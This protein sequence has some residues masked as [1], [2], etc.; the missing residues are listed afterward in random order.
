MNSWKSQF[1]RLYFCNIFGE[2]THILLQENLTILQQ[3]ALLLDDICIPFNQP[4]FQ[5]IILH[6][7]IIN[8]GILN[9]Y[10]HYTERHL[11]GKI[12]PKTK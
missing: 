12:I 9:Q 7:D 4:E 8:I 11:C 5:D 6:T 10:G 2:S 1:R 3:S